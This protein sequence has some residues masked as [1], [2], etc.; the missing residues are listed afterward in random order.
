MKHEASVLEKVVELRSQATSKKL[1]T[2][3]KQE[4]NQKLSQG[5]SQIMIQAEQYPELKSN[6]NFLDLQE[7][8]YSVE[9]NISASRRFYNVA[10][11]DYNNAIEMF[12]SSIFAR[13]MGLSRKEVF[14]IPEIERKNVN[15]AQLF[16]HK[17]S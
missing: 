10:V 6:T 16:E 12:P 2:E 7:T 14:S 4:L 17:A 5:L 3:G 11:T 1:S 15:L 8:I 13:M 9:E